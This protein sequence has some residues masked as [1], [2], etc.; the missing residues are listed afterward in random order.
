[1]FH[2]SLG[3][4]TGPETRWL[5]GWRDDCEG[6][7]ERSNSGRKSRSELAFSVSESVVMLSVLL[8]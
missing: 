4:R 8:T 2:W 5:D 3:I 6:E 7:N 1:M